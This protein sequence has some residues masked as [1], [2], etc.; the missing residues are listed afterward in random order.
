MTLYIT[1]QCLVQV[2]IMELDFFFF[3]AVVNES[4]RFMFARKCLCVEC[5][6]TTALAQPR[7]IEI[8]SCV[9]PL[10]RYVRY[11]LMQKHGSR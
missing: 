3:E 11:V 4:M 6:S 9:V 8:L 7:C 1:T 5:G 10:W 2:Y